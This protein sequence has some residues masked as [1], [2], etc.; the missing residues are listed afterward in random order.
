MTSASSRIIRNMRFLQSVLLLLLVALVVTIPT[1]PGPGLAGREAARDELRRN[2]TWLQYYLRPLSVGLPCLLGSTSSTSP[3]T[4]IAPSSSLQANT[5]PAAKNP[6][7][8]LPKEKDHLGPLG[9]GSFPT[10]EEAK[11]ETSPVGHGSAFGF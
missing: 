4:K 10:Q 2:C 3:P 7:K 8:Y 5:T 1:P 9:R 11:K 6:L